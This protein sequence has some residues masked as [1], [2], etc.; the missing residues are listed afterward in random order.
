MRIC[1]IVIL[2]ELMVSTK[3][4]QLLIGLTMVMNLKCSFGEILVEITM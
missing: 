1:D 2:L 3:S 4:L